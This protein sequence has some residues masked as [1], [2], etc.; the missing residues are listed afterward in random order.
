MIALVP[1]ETM[2]RL[3]LKALSQEAQNDPD[4]DTTPYGNI[5]VVSG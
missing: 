4:G 1:V 5:I 3:A 2:I